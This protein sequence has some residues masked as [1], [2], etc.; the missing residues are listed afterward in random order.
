MAAAMVYM[1]AGSRDEALAIG[2]ALVEERLAACVNL[3]DH[4]TSLYWWQGRIEQG[5]EV[6]LIAKT[7]QELVPQLISRVRELH[8]YDCPSVVAWP[9]A[10]GNPQYLDWIV[11]ETRDL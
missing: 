8:S 4:M 11:D 10:A 5:E 6:V 3:L 2:R 7:K 1:T 9:I